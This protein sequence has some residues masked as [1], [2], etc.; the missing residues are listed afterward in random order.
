MSESISNRRLLLRRARPEWPS[1][2][3]V[4]RYVVP[5]VLTGLVVGFF[6]THGLNMMDGGLILAESHRLLQGEIPHADFITPRPAGSAFVHLIDFALPLPLL[7]ASRLVTVAEFVAYGTLFGLLTFRCGWRQ[8]GVPHVIAIAAATLVNMH[9]FPL[10]PFYT[11]DGLVLV[12]AGF[13]L[14]DRA[15]ASDS[16]MPATAG[17]LALGAVV[18]VKQSFWFAPILGVVWV[19]LASRRGGRIRRALPRMILVASMPAIAYVC[20]V[21]AGGG[22]SEMRAQLTNASPVWGET[23]VDPFRVEGWPFF[24]LRLAAIS[25]LYL[26]ILGSS[27]LRKSKGE[28]PIEHRVI[29]VT[30]RLTLTYLILSLALAEDLGYNRNWSE[31]LFWCAFAVIALR[32][33]VRRQLDVAG[34]VVVSTAW[35]VALSWGA[36]TPGL[37]GGTVALYVIY[38]TWQDARLPVS[39][40]SQSFVLAGVA[41][42]LF[43]VA[44][45]FATVRLDSEYGVPVASMTY[46]LGSIATTLRGVRADPANA[47]YLKDVVNC[48][49]QYPA[50]SVGVIPEGALAYPTLGLT[51]PFPIDWFWHDDYRGAGRERLLE[52][53]EELARRGDYLVL[54]QTQPLGRPDLARPGT[55]AP[56]YSDPALADEIRA[57]LVGP[58]FQCGQFVAVYRPAAG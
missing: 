24:V 40:R 26:A 56:F 39:L 3:T 30:L 4:V 54:F 29:D 7:L 41:A 20:F 49:D 45:V 58:E 10:I 18:T 16:V 47:S 12:G 46:E 27:A 50:R 15:I 9:T 21:A 28:L 38:R 36:P 22:L 35:M 31:R 37:L 5:V 55:I 25:A 34:A 51:N 11:I 6:G 2:V 23:L 53:T 17:A 14:I 43:F 8:L 19:L 44:H 57:R 32:S 48:R 52:A 33:I 13:V 42:A 1:A